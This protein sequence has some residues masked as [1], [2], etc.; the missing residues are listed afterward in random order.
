MKV[1]GITGGI[2]SGKSTML[3]YIRDT[4]HVRV[5]E[6]DKVGHEVMKKGQPCYDRI[7][8]LFGD[9][10]LKDNKEIDRGK[11]G[12]K[13]FK[14]ELLLQ[15]LNSI[16]HP[17]VKTYIKGEIEKEKKE[18]KYPFFVIEAAL[19]IED[20]YD[21]ICDELWYIHASPSVRRKRLKESRNYSDQKMDEIFRK[22]LS[23]KIF[24]ERCD[25]IVDNNGGCEPAFSQIDRG[26]KEHEF[27]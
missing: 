25:F 3:S 22:Q 24:R 16:V 21:E 12:Q 17:A 1:L 4:Y 2:G 8:G 18:Q 19:L 11:L 13:V 9:D 5:M 23:E 20:H 7:V 6:A 15:A 27:V 14:H 10:I 26:L